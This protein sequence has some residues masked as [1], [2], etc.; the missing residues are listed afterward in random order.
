MFETAPLTEAVTIQ[1]P[2][3]ARLYVSS[4]SVDGMLAVSVSD[5]APDG[6]VSRLTG[7]WQV[8]SHRALDTGRSRYLDGRLVQPWHRFTRA[9]K[10]PLSAGEVAPVDVEVFPTGAKVRP[11]HRLRL[12]VQ[13]TDVP[14]LAPTAA[15]L[16]GNAPVIRV[17]SSAEHPSVLTLPTVR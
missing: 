1:G 11:G 5:V 8:I 10:K 16:P 2:I 7:G 6:T 15:D 4:T 12:S 14:H 3:N 17:H 13:A 9:A